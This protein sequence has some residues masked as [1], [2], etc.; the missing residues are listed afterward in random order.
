MDLNGRVDRVIARNNAPDLSLKCQTGVRWEAESWGIGVRW[1]SLEDAAPVLQ[2]PRLDR[3]AGSRAC[4]A[5]Q[6][7]HELAEGSLVHHL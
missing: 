2:A 1:G 4:L 5:Y 3:T 7:A 6:E